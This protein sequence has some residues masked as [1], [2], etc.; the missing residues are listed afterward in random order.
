MFK[1]LKKASVKAAASKLDTSTIDGLLKQARLKYNTGL[2]KE[3]IEA[4]NSV[5]KHPELILLDEKDNKQNHK[6]NTKNTKDV[7]GKKSQLDGN[8]YRM[9]GQSHYLLY[10]DTNIQ[11][12]ID[13][14][15]ECYQK[16]IDVYK[17]IDPNVFCEAAE[18]YR[19]HNCHPSAL[20]LYGVIIQYWPV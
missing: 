15:L 8:F 7:H 11:D 17:F 2:Y 10:K 1:K 20:E 19:C 4:F 12:D 9:K 18:V 5:L 13:L 14:A 3:A 16:A 6:K